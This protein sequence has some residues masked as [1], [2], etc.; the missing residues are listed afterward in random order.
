MFRILFIFI[1]ICLP[2]KAD[3]YD[4]RLEHLFNQLLYEDDEKKINTITLNIWDIWHETNDPKI[5]ADF[6]RGIGLMY[7]G[8]LKK[9]IIYFSK[10]IEKNP[11]FAEAWNK[12]ATVYYMLGQYDKSMFDIKTTLELEPRHFGAMDGMISIFLKQEKFKE[13]IAIYDEIIKI[14]PKSKVTINKRKKLQN[15]KLNSA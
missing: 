14:F 4:S 3:Q 9:S 1:I 10:V 8:K 12:R 5:N 6:F 15:Y 13:A 11:Y 2:I 7:D